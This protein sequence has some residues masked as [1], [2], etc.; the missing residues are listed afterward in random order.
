M[1]NYLGKCFLGVTARKPCYPCKVCCFCCWAI[2]DQVKRERKKFSFF[3]ALKLEQIPKIFE[4]ASH[5]LVKQIS[6]NSI[7][8]HLCNNKFSKPRIKL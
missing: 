7:L 2:V 4:C 1:K 5:S 3:V 8:H 6:Q